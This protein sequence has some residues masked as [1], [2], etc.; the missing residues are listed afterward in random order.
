MI[1][2]T[3]MILILMI[4]KDMTWQQWSSG[5]D[6]PD[7]QSKLTGAA[8]TRA[9]EAKEQLVIT[10][11]KHIEMA[12]AQRVLYQEKEKKARD[13]VKNEVPHSERSVCVSA[14]FGQN[15][16][17]PCFNSKQPGCT[18]YYSPLTINNFGV[19]DHSHKYEN[20]TIGNHMYCHVYH[21]GIGKKGGT[22]VASLLVHPSQKMNVLLENDPCRIEY[23]YGQLLWPE[24][25]QYC[26]KACCNVVKADGI[27]QVSP[28]YI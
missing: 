1:I 25:E 26:A 20:G 2:L 23:F 13:D 18:Y 3:I 27:L 8:A 12:R 10:C 4:S 16:E 24:Q 15:Q 9:R 6:T 19:V 17:V 14:D 5:A 22:N 28:C 11:K 7:H 21:E